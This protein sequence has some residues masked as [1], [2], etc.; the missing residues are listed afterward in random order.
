MIPVRKFFE[1][2]GYG[3]VS[4]R[5]YYV[6]DPSKLPPSKSGTEWR[7]DL[8]FDERAAVEDD[9]KLSLVL[10]EARTRGSALLTKAI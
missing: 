4:N 10:A 1:D 5:I 6:T 3:R 8:Q 7:E 2:L 9:P